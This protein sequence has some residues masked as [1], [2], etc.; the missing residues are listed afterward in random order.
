[1]KAIIVRARDNWKTGDSIEVTAEEFA[2]LAEDGI[3]VTAGEYAA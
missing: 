2:V 3:A 1:M